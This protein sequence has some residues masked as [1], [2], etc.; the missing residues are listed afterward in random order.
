MIRVSRVVT[1][2]P[3]MCAVVLASSAT[4]AY[5]I[6]YASDRPAALS[7]CD[8]MRYSGDRIAATSCFSALLV[9]ETDDRLRA[10]AAWGLGDIRSANGYF[11]SAIGTY[12]DDAALR[13][14]WGRLFSE[15]HD[16]AEAVKLYQEALGLDP[17]YVP[18]IIGLAEISAGRFEDRSREWIEDA[19][20]LEPDAIDAHLLLARTELEIGNLDA[21]EAALDEAAE[22]IAARGLAPLELY[23]LY[24]SLDLLRDITDSEWTT[25]AL[26]YNAAYGG[27]YATPAYFYVITRRY[28]EAIEL[29]RKAVEIEPD[30]YEA[31]ADL[32]VNLLRVNLID[33]AQDH[34]ARAYAGDPYSARTVNTL[35]LIDSL[36]RFEVEAFGPDSGTRHEMLLR[37]HQD[38]AGILEPYVQALID[39]SID[40]FSERYQFELKE[41]VIVEFYPDHD[42]FA[43]R[44]AGLPGIGLLGVTFGY[45]VAMDSPSGRA[46]GDFHW[47]TTLWHEMAHVFTLETT[48]HLV[49]RWFSEGVSVFEEWASGPLNGRHIPINVIQAMTEDKFLPIAE[50]DS[51]FIRPTYADQ[52][53]VSYMQAGMICE[54]IAGR[55]G[56]QALVDMLEGFRNGLDTAASLESA[57]EIDA[58]TFDEL[59]AERVASEFGAVLENFEPWQQAQSRAHEHAANNAWLDASAAAEQAVELYPDYVDEGSA[60][61]LLAKAQSEAE[62]EDAAVETLA[63]YHRRGGYDPG[64]LIQLGRWQAE[65][66]NGEAALQVY[67]DALLV[68]PLSEEVHAEYGDL[69]LEAGRAEDAVQEFEALFALQPHDEAAAR[70]RL[71]KAYLAAGD[72]DLANE[73]LLYALEI[74]P[75]FREAQQLLLEMIN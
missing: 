60:Y 18:A 41:P 20:D 25:R 33:E 64:A 16:D 53:I 69:L 59:F 61:L 9:N 75:H 15:T 24:V 47:G 74:A 45:L 40:A 10:E 4:A 42:D 63:E 31:H 62:N 7:A 48:D 46:E 32:G 35:R 52:V 57:L 29:F 5:R 21:A 22:L 50:L 44:T 72:R 34:L 11:Q 68:A 70:F 43:V 28:R 12:P 2:A 73:H 54:F 27:I 13:T 1:F 37:L 56:Q 36:D 65:R 67:A 26:D 8:A 30:H 39:D 14:R 3:L 23:S 17:E 19:L 71:A 55:W 66:E 51:G 58:P 38:E 49:P 6:E